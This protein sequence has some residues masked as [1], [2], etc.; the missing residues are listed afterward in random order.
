M[1][2]N[3]SKAASGRTTMSGPSGPDRRPI[4]REWRGGGRAARRAAGA[5]GD[6]RGRSGQEL[7]TST[8]TSPTMAASTTTAVTMDRPARARGEVS[9]QNERPG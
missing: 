6:G 8:Q 4:R 3:G 7:P 9:S 1:G 2:A 5:K